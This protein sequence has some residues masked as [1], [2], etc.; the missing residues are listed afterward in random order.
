MKF[1]KRGL[2]AAGA[3]ALAAAFLNVT[4]PKIVHAAVA[5]LVQVANTTANPAI[6]SNMDDPGRIPY[7]SQG[8]YSPGPTECI[9]EGCLL[10]FGPVPANHRLVVQHLAVRL[11]FNQAPGQVSLDYTGTGFGGGLTS[12]PAAFNNLSAGLVI[13]DAFELPVQFY[14]DQSQSFQVSMLAANLGGF[15]GGSVTATGYM[16]DCTAAPCSAIAH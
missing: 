6:V 9:S 15:L 16:L 7:Q 13:L 5:A 11:V 2:M 1:L 3:L 10:H 12:A 4:A 8:V 14:V